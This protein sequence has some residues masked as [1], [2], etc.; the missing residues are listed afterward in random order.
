MNILAGIIVWDPM[1]V[2][3]FGMSLVVLLAGVFC[4]SVWYYNR[5]I[6]LAPL[7]RKI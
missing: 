2:F 3:I 7:L 5:A 6:D 4:W 1:V